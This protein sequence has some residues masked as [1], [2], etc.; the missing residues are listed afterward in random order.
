MLPGPGD[1]SLNRLANARAGLGG[2]LE[3][4][5]DLRVA[6][7]FGCSV[8]L[9]TMPQLDFYQN[10]DQKSVIAAAEEQRLCEHSQSQAAQGTGED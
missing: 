2:K 1:Q 6:G 9:P 8:P 4:W 7:A 5:L 10:L 3:A